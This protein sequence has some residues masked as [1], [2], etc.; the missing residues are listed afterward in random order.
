M[1]FTLINL[2]GLGLLGFVSAG[3]LQ[4]QNAIAMLDGPAFRLVSDED[5]M[6][7]KQVKHHIEEDFVSFK[8]IN[9]VHIYLDK[10]KLLFQKHPK[11]VAFAQGDLKELHSFLSKEIV[12]KLYRV[13]AEPFVMPIGDETLPLAQRAVENDELVRKLFGGPLRSLIESKRQNLAGKEEGSHKDGNFF[14]NFW[15]KIS[16]CSN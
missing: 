5:Q 1:K 14:T 16:N 15:C 7:M 11:N 12:N 9:D 10:V 8:N 2:L 6:L 3:A 4:E 13:D